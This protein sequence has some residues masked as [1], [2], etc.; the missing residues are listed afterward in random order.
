M[1]SQVVDD[2]WHAFILNTRSYDAFCK[3]AFGRF[4]HHVPSAALKSNRHSNTGLRRCWWYTC[5]E[6]NINP[7]N[8][9]RLPLLFAL[10][11]KLQIAGG[12]HYVADCSTVRRLAERGSDA[13]TVYCG[14]DFSDNS[15]DGST[16]G[17]GDASGHGSDAGHSGSDA[18]G[19]GGSD[20]CGG[21]GCGGD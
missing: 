3:Q 9:T 4:L 14:G 18:D 19:G 13:A 16:D 6:E 11:T 1:P 7:R 12:F 15:F 21:G 8:A 2:L 10:D 17:F 5:K 20:G